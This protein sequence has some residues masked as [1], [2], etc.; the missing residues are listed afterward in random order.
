MYNNNLTTSI[1]SSNQSKSNCKRILPKNTSSINENNIQEYKVFLKLPD[2]SSLPI[3]TID[4]STKQ[5]TTTFSNAQSINL[6][7][8]DRPNNYSPIL[9]IEQEI[10]NDNNNNDI[11]LNKTRR[12]STKKLN[13][14]D[15][16]ET[17]TLKSIKNALEQSTSQLN[18]LE[19][20][21]SNCSSQSSTSSYLPT[22]PIN[23]N[24]ISLDL[25]TNS[26]M[27]VNN[28]L[29]SNSLEQS[30]TKFKPGRRR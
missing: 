4:S 3:S 23:D 25:S 2:G 19:S 16:V 18:Q 27:N 21:N 15:K 8:N 17:T 12:N 13:Q 20:A 14:L 24:S 1:K 22:P 30:K 7:S 6:E 28:N 29:I 9:P 5:Q 10:L 26:L 11:Q